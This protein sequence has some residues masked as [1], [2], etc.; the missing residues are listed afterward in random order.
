MRG[1]LVLEELIT[2]LEDKINQLS[3]S[4]LLYEN[5]DDTLS[6]S[7]MSKVF[8]Q[9]EWH[10]EQAQQLDIKFVTKLDRFKQINEIT[11]LDALEI[12]SQEV[13]KLFEHLK[14]KITITQEKEIILKDYERQ[15]EASHKLVDKGRF[16]AIS[17]YK[18]INK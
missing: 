17:A 9:L 5:L 13:R 12:K 4:I 18:N 16:K 14:E 8:D 2:I 7:I 11:S 3:S 15:L 6:P 1:Q 10:K